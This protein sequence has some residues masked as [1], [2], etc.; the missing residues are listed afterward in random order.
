L[1]DW[2]L[3]WAFDLPHSIFL[4]VC[5]IDTKPRLNTSS[6]VNVVQEPEEKEVALLGLGTNLADASVYP[7]SVRMH[8]TV[9]N[10][11][12]RLWNCPV[13]SNGESFS[14]AGTVGSTEACLLAGLALKFRWREWYRKKH[15]LT[16]VQVIGVVPNLIISTCYQAAWEKCFRYFDVEPR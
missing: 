4:L 8:D 15:N 7:A 5:F 10:M 9:V 11:I 14:G 6:Y 1:I 3:L 12:A 2:F 13:P 16:P